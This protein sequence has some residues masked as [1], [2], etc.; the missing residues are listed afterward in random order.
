ME[1]CVAPT[2]AL[3]LRTPHAKWGPRCAA[4]ALGFP[5]MARSP[6]TAQPPFSTGQAP[7]SPPDPPPPTPCPRP[8]SMSCDRAQAAPP[9]GPV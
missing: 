3:V 2:T 4:R 8:L 5:L 9:S 1:R 6:T 7:H